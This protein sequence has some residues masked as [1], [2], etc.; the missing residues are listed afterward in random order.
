MM[1]MGSVL[2]GRENKLHA[3]LKLIIHERDVT[4]HVK[5]ALTWRR[6]KM[7]LASG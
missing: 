3:N 2:D 6:A 7:Y 4:L 5:F 1:T